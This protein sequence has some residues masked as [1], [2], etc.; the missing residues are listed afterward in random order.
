MNLSWGWHK[1]P[2]GVAQLD[3]G[4]LPGAE[5]LKPSCS[6]LKKVSGCDSPVTDK[7][8]KGNEQPKV[9]SP[10]PSLPWGSRVAHRPVTNSFSSLGH[11]ENHTVRNGGTNARN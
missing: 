3:I 11:C 7:P 2:V 10:T 6:A 5:L 8:F 4:T 9:L 1:G